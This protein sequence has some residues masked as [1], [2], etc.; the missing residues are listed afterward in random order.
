MTQKEEGARFN[1]GKLR[2]DLLEPYAVEQLVQVF[3]KG[4]DKYAPRN[5]EKGMAWSKMVASLKRHLA[6]FEKGNDYDSETKLLHASHIAWNA[7]ALVSYYKIAPHF[8]DRPHK[9]LKPRRIALDIDDVLADWTG[10]WAKLHNIPR[11]T[12]WK[13]DRYIKEK[14][15]SMKSDGDSGNSEL[16][17]FYLNLPV[18]TKPQDI[19]F[20]P[21]LY[22]TSRPVDSKIT[23]KWL[24]MNGFPAAPVV[25][26]GIDGSKLDV[27]LKNKID[28]FVDDRY[29]T[30]IELNNGGVC[31]YLFDALHNQRYDV[32]HKRIYSLTEIIP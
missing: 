19:F 29:E 17:K 7:M 28:I 2:Y 9:Y 26:V 5:W 14:F 13:F 30:F 4:A 31:T 8:D 10:E 12:A 32:G 16:D 24:D 11:P 25:T 22:V 18:L 15:S 3:T 27:L 6:E 20:E 1:Q 23:E 21:V